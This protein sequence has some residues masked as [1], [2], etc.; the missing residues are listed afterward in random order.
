[1]E[2]LLYEGSVVDREREIHI[3]YHII[4]S[5]PGKVQF[6]R[7]SKM[8]GGNCKLQNFVSC[9]TAFVMTM[10]GQGLLHI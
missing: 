4:A 9:E 7:L 2:F 5:L 10:E 3:I 8:V 1:M 6:S